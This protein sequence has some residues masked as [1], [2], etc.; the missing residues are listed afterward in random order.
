MCVCTDFL[1]WKKQRRVQDLYFLLQ[2]ADFRCISGIG[3]IATF[4]RARRLCINALDLCI[5]YR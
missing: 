1:D 4:Q 3:E 2:P 5:V